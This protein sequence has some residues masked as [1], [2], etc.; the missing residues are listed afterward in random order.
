M[1][2]RELE[3]AQLL[4][5]YWSA[6]SRDR[7][8]SP[9]E[10]LDPGLAAT[11]RQLESYLRPPEP[12]AA[13]AQ[14]LRGR[15]EAEAADLARRSDGSKNARSRGWLRLI[16]G[17]GGRRILSL[18]AALLVLLVGAVLAAGAV[19]VGFESPS[20]ESF[21]PTALKDVPGDAAI[22][23]TFDRPMLAP[24]AEGALSIEPAVEGSFS[25]RGNTMLFTP[26]SGW[27]RGTRYSVRLEQSARSLLLL[28]LKEPVAYE[29]M[30]AKELSVVA[31][32]PGD[33]A[34]DVALDSSIAVQ[35]SYPIVPL[36]TTGG[37]PNPLRIEPALK[38]KG[39]WLTTSLY[40]FQPEG[41]LAAG[42]RYTVT[43]PGGLKDTAGS[44]LA[45]DYR[46]SFTTKAPAVARVSPENNTRFVGPGSEVR[47]GFDQPVEHAS[48][49][50]RFS[51]K[52]PDGSPVAGSFAWEGET[53]V[54][55]P[56][57]PLKLETSYR[58]TMAAG[59]KAA[60]GGGQT[61]EFSWS[62]T[63]VGSPK[64]VSS[65]PS[66]GAMLPAYESVQLHFSNPMDQE[67][68][69]KSISLSPKPSQWH[70]GWQDS[71]TRLFIWGGL[72]P[73]TR[74]TLTLSG[75]A[76]DR[77]GQ[78]LG[79]P[80]AITFTTAPLP[81]G[82]RAAMPGFV[83][84]FNAARS[85]VL[86]VE[87]V[88]V[89]R[90]D[91][92]LYR[93]EQSDFVR[94]TS[95][96]QARKGYE[97]KD[98]KL[99]RRW[100][101]KPASSERDKAILTPTSLAGE[102]G[103]KLPTGLYFLRIESPEGF[104]DDRLLVVSRLGLSMKVSQS[105][106]LVWATD[107]NSGEVVPNLPVR[108]VRA[109]GT[110]LASG[111]TDRDGVMLATGIP[112]YDPRRGPPQTFAFAEG[113]GD[114]GAVGSD[115]AEG[116]YPYNFKLP[117]EPVAQPYRGYLYTDRPIYRPGQKVLFKGIVRGDDD[118]RYT[119]PP[120]GT[121]LT[122][123][124]VDSR[125]RKMQS[126]TVALND[127]GTFDGELP[128][129]M[130]APLG[131]YYISARIGD[132]GFGVGFSV[133][134]YRK[135]EFEVKI[136]ADRDSYVHGDRI[137][138]AASASY[139][140]GQ[141]LA[142]AQVRWRVT[143]RNHLFSALEGAYQFVDYDL[144]REARAEG[145]RVRTEGKGVLDGRGNIAFEVPADLTKDALSQQFSIE[146]TI[147]DANNQ[148][149]SARTEVV[150]H[151]GERYV[152]LRP[153]RYVA[154]VGESAAVELVVVDK[155]GRIVPNAPATVSFYSR[156]WLSVKERQ[157]DGS[158]FWT[159]KP[160][161]TL[162]STRSVTTGVDGRARAS[163]EAREAGSIRVVAEVAD[164]RGNKM[165]SATY[166]YV[167]GTGFASWRMES[168][169][170]MDLIA[171][172]EEYS[173]GDT[174]RVLIPAP[175]PD[176][177]ALVTVE[178]GKLL[179]HRLVR[180]KG[181]SD[182]L[183]LPV[184]LEY[185][186]NVY[187]S[188]IVFKG[189]GAGGIPTFKV[190]YGE[191]KVA[192]ADRALKIDLK[193]DKTR[194]EPGEKA[195][196]SIRTV[197]STGKGVPA[198][199]SLAVVDVAVLALAE[200]GKRDLMDA[201]WARRPL[202]VSTSATLSLSVDRHNADLS[203]ERKG[204]GGGSEGPTVRREFPDTAYWNPAVRTN[205]RGEAT[206]AVTLPDSLTTWRAT[207]RGVTASTQ[208]GSASADAIA[209]KSLL[210]R[211]A[212]PR[213]LLMGDRLQLAALLHNYTDREV[214]VEVSLS[215]SGVRPDGDRGFASQQV[216]V[217]SGGLVRLEWPARVESVPG[218]GSKAVIGF[219][220]RPITSG[221]PGDSVEMTLPVH[222]LTTAE[223]VATSGEVRDS[224][225]ELVRVPKGANPAL[226]ELT[227]ETS[228]S[229]AAGMRYSAH[230]LDE[231]PYECTEQT[232]SRFLPRVVMQRAFEK[233]GL[234]DREGIAARLPSIVERS[235]QRL[236]A[237]QRPDGGWGWWQGDS[238]DQWI[239]AYAV[240][241][242]AEA[243]RSGYTVDQG[244]L[245]RAIQFL[246]R[247]L[248]VPTDV[249][250][251]ENPNSRAYVLY[252]MAQAGKGDLGLANALYDRR[253][254]LGN[255][256]KAYLL[257]ALH[258]MGSGTQDGKLQSLVSDLA[259][260]AIASASGVHWEESQVDRRTMNTNTRS[261]AIVL[262][263]L[264]KAAPDSPQIPS[265]VRWLMV[266]RKEGHWETTQETAMSLLALTD[267]MEATGELEGDFAYRVALNGRE[268]ALQT[269][270]RENVDEARKLVV[271]IKDLLAADDNRLNIARAKP[272]F[273]Q[274]G[275]GKLYYTMHLRYFAPSEQVPAISQGLALLR[276]YYR[277]GDEAAGPVDRVSP[278]ETVKVKLTLIA[279]QDLHYLVVE[280]PLPSGLEAVDTRLKTT[281]LAAREET[282]MRRT[283][284][285]DRREAERRK[286]GIPWWEY[287]YFQHVEPRDDRV[288][289]FATYLPK[290]SYEYS[291][292]ARATTSGEFQ[293]L[294]A[295]GYEMYFP[296]VWGRSE[297]GKMRVGE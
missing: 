171:D 6:L 110:T 285:P 79:R 148:E 136:A 245:E 117:W 54:F 166:L 158:Y 291:Y 229:L 278:G 213:F 294:P 221:V 146:A 106:V 23:I 191:L 84:T 215:A 187:V 18:A 289:L 28:P 116:I 25:W 226:G 67:S 50:Q 200:E 196:Y 279:L 9:P 11:V 86:Y 72:A 248:D 44:A 45:E 157:P 236:Y 267:Y 290:G 118:A 195:T 272:A 151:K 217:A 189:G 5:T 292:L 259:S 208:V 156:K 183:E 99:V 179:S 123:D 15:L 268:L 202:G 233:L 153:E 94:L 10:G 29:F 154:R 37:E 180:L 178:R 159:S 282:G 204:A 231:F 155:D 33:G 57:A 71:D 288:A 173:V 36:G 222:T 271:E 91:F 111:R 175:V 30:T 81:P 182:T 230:Y 26:R 19:A 92:S 160:E 100:S 63:T 246:R 73:S 101:E 258:A 51:L 262:D 257:M 270:N 89:S 134:E 80:V 172:K 197:D 31:V 13:F 194:Y 56:G 228:P 274:S 169:D 120:A 62:F 40:L 1:A 247:S 170:R 119:V 296:E 112:A 277:L 253:S 17:F 161:D 49:E 61:A 68:V 297:G 205:E 70:V 126:S 261:T 225:T 14:A 2:E 87:H 27:A 203:T 60:R 193:P 266:A 283:D 78:K 207:A 255:Y 218:G 184:P 220:A 211:P 165:R 128:L 214:E 113:E 59:V 243:R 143:S 133:A 263:A 163:L 223:V 77:Y 104:S 58:A 137:P 212:L 201:F 22:A 124:I 260:S 3:Q 21:G 7:G 144:L 150:V 145:D 237:G 64:V 130:E 286:F 167:S 114:V 127:M 276:E 177:L 69:E 52:A 227:V 83:G 252:V 198:E 109:D 96:G 199:L 35:F 265:A 8:A 174:A 149:T 190:G 139:Y 65:V 16:P 82:M 251:P 90:L 121:E 140:F 12:E 41:G 281:S 275:Q 256:G 34:S 129:A 138:V 234:A 55:R 269:V 232:V 85:P 284:D 210:L 241:G 162:I 280:D 254:I 47:V 240:H 135:P 188:A 122:L 43:V 46:W 287:S 24:L 39:R 105:Q 224:T 168:H 98:E 74:Y 238:S 76:V 102:Q 142:D 176:A 244:V 249:L 250:H 186:P 209:S 4:E 219:T 38:G 93:V 293:V 48:A 107:L 88:N 75:D 235:L 147:V 141:P 115:W 42:V 20:V 192:T 242:L 95:S 66:P 239:T 152:G 125:G 53:L 132:W 216:R 295:R 97:L 103:G 206:V 181:N 32:Q 131:N 164:G 185:L 273:G 264:V 108:V